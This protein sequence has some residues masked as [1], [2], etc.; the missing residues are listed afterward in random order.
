MSEIVFPSTRNPWPQSF[1]ILSILDPDYV[2]NIDDEIRKEVL[3]FLKKFESLSIHYREEALRRSLVMLPQDYYCALVAAWKAHNL[4]AVRI[5][6]F[7][8][9]HCNQDGLEID[10]GNA[11]T[12]HELLSEAFETEREKRIY[13]AGVKHVL[14]RWIL[15]QQIYCSLAP[16]DMG[17]VLT[18]CP[19]NYYTLSHV[20]HI[21][22]VLGSF[23]SKFE[24]DLITDFH[25]GSFL[26]MEGRIGRSGLLALPD[27]S[28]EKTHARYENAEKRTRDSSLEG[29]YLAVGH[30]FLKAV[31]DLVLYDNYVEYSF[32]ENLFGI[33]D[34][35]LRKFPIQSLIRQGRL[36][37]RDAILHYGDDEILNA[38]TYES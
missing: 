37:R 29:E 31:R 23:D 36:E 17:K 3:P 14:E 33:P 34:L 30:P 26:V 1:R 11:E 8:S 24:R 18:V 22:Y 38:L 4:L 35:L 12:A 19:F 7:L 5:D 27:S 28:L 13:S 2:R 9:I 20:R 21:E 32:S 6:E 15:R 16:D 10:R 25:A